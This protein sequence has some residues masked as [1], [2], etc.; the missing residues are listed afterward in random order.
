MDQMNSEAAVI[1]KTRDLP[2]WQAASARWQAVAL[3]HQR[4]IA[5]LEAEARQAGGNTPIAASRAEASM[6]PAGFTRIKLTTTPLAI[7]DT[8]DGVARLWTDHIEIALAMQLKHL[9]KDP[10]VMEALARLGRN[11]LESYS[12]KSKIRNLETVIPYL[13]AAADRAREA[14]LQHALALPDDAPLTP[15]VREFLE[16]EER[17]LL[18]KLGIAPS[19]T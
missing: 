15:Q 8:A 7:L 14:A 6:L 9:E 3:A 4:A 1:A 2:A 19:Q 13:Q 5:V 17:R 12:L 11:K 16:A 10:G 18:E